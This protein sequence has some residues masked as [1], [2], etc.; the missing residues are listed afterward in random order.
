MPLSTRSRGQ[1]LMLSI[2]PRRLIWTASPKRNRLIKSSPIFVHPPPHPPL[3]AKLRTSLLGSTARLW[4][5]T[6]TGTPGPFVPLDFRRPVFNALHSLSHPGVCG[7]QKIVAER[8]IWPRMNADVRAWARA[9]LACR[10]SKINRY[11]ISPPS[12]FLPPDARFDEVHIDLVSPLPPAK[13]YRYLLS[14]ID[15][16]T[17][18]PEVTPIPDITAE[19]VAHAFFFSWVSRFGV[20]STVTTDRGRQFEWALF[21]HLCF[22]LGTHH[23]RITAHH[24][25]ANG[26]VERLHWQ[27][28]A[29]LRATD[30]SDTTWPERL[31]FVLLGLRAAIRQDGCSAPHN[32]LRLQGAFFTPSA[33]LSPRPLLVRR[34]SPPA[35]P[36]LQAHTYPLR[37]R[38]R[39]VR[40]PRPSSI[41]ILWSTTGSSPHCWSRHRLY[42]PLRPPSLRTQLLSPAFLPLHV[43]YIGPR[44]LGSTSCLP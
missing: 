4:C 23:I 44:R 17:R 5:D 26:L 36:G 1:T 3:F 38:N 43:G 37:S 22:A 24:P 34:P 7:T 10:R 8:Y 35:L 20:P 18:W 41:L 33:P 31:P 28:K 14:C 6:S 30:H 40:E 27:L 21:R 2:R 12:R 32:G 9:C 13:G 29:S 42:H 39:R 25:P 16:F 19:T 15:R 11:T